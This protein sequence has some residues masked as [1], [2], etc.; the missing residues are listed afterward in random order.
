MKEEKERERRKEYPESGIEERRDNRAWD[1]GGEGFR[2]RSRSRRR[3]GSA[4]PM[5]ERS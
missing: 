2:R 4:L 3:H 1:N 5:E